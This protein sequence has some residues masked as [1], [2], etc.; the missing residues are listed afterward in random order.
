MSSKE[1]WC[2]RVDSPHEMIWSL[3]T[4]RV[5]DCGASR[6]GP[7]ASR[8]AWSRRVDS[9]WPL[10]QRCIGGTRQWEK[11]QSWR[12]M[13]MIMHHIISSS[14]RVISDLLLLKHRV[15]PSIYF[16][17]S[18]CTLLSFYYSLT[19][20]GYLLFSFYIGH[21]QWIVLNNQ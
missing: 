15:P 2:V 3:L 13:M 16:L 4:T 14:S 5:L 19:S 7:V 18:I 10:I 9:I 17:F 20:I 12:W 8:F 21:I 6:F 11:I 1:V